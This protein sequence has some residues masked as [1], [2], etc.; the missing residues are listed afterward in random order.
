MAC[1]HIF[2]L[3]AQRVPFRVMLI[4]GKWYAGVAGVDLCVIFPIP[5]AHIAFVPHALRISCVRDAMH[6]LGK[7]ALLYTLVAS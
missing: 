1:V 4:L 5:R 2:I 6:V 3:Y 7:C